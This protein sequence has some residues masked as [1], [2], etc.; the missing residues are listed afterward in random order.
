[1]QQCC[2]RRFYEKVK[3][4]DKPR[5]GCRKPET[6]LLFLEVV[7]NAFFVKQTRTFRSR[8]FENSSFNPKRLHNGSELTL[9]IS[10]ALECSP[11]EGSK[12]KKL[13]TYNS[14]YRR[15]TTR[16][17]RSCV[18]VQSFGRE[19]NLRRLPTKEDKNSQCLN[20]VEYLFFFGRRGDDKTRKTFKEEDPVI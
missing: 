11:K 2:Q 14:L 6:R 8:P 13:K 4:V 12:N 10:V 15:K 20:V 5:E 3:L 1:M 17:S 7:D 19:Q 16:Y 9:S 18:S